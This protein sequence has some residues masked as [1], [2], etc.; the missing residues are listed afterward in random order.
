MCGKTNVGATVRRG[1]KYKTSLREMMNAN[2]QGLAGFLQHKEKHRVQRAY[3]LTGL[4]FDIFMR[5][6]IPT[7]AIHI[8]I[9]TISTIKLI[10]Q[11]PKKKKSCI[12]Q[13]NIF[14]K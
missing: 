3:G 8:Y 10:D 4:R 6:F 2:S 14:K 11:V 5:L 12:S 13:K 1:S 9:Y 7:L